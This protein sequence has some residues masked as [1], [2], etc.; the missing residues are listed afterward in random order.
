FVADRFEATG[1][2]AGDA[3][4]ALIALA[5]GHPQRICFLADALWQQTPEGQRADL[6][7][8]SAA[9]DLALRRGNA[10]FSAIEAGLE[11]GQRKMARVLAAGEPPTGSFAERLELSKGGA[12]GAL[13]A[14]VD[15]GHVH[16]RD[17]RY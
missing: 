16:E 1:R 3:L 7:T 10:E 5:G 13:S 4:R 2:D 8:W 12:R 15:R 9:L 6:A 17:G 11:P 14:L